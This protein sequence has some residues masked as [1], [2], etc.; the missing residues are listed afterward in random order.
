MAHEESAGWN[1]L[2]SRE[3]SMFTIILSQ[4]LTNID[5]LLRLRQIGVEP[6]VPLDGTTGQPDRLFDGYD[7]FAAKTERQAIGILQILFDCR[8]PHALLGTIVAQDQFLSY[9]AQS[10]RQQ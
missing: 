2:P 9:I 6:K 1:T 7:V 4:G 10:R 3:G 8:V 5:L